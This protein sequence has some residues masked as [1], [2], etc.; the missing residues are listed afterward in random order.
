MRVL[1]VEDA[2][3]AVAWGWGLPSARVL[4]KPT[5]APSHLRAGPVKG[6]GLRSVYPPRE[7][8]FCHEGAKIGSGE[9]F[10]TGA[11]IGSGVGEIRGSKIGSG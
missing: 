3:Y 7:S 2:G 11:T 8:L 1:V 4:S 9:S 10:R 6:L 5:A